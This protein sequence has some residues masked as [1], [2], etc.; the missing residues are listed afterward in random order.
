MSEVIRADENKRSLVNALREDLANAPLIALVNYEKITVDQVN[1]VRRAFEERGIRYFVAKNSLINL[2]VKGTEREGLGQ[3]LKGMTGVI[4]SGED[5][6]ETAKIVRSTVKEFK[7]ET[8]L[9]KGGFFDGDV[10]DEKQIDKV[11]DLPSKEELLTTLLRTLQ[12]GP[13]QVLG[14]IQ[15]PARDLVNLLKNYENKLSE[16]E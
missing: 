2:A 15:G 6:I 10:L 14:V 1:T 4:L 9:L 7:G 5:A 11:A 16:S 3:Y 8:F 12:E 13:R